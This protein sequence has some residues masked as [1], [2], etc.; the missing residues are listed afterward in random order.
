[1]RNSFSSDVP[2][3][4]SSPSP[5]RDVIAASASQDYVEPPNSA[6]YP[7]VKK[8]TTHFPDALFDEYDGARTRSLHPP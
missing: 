7:F 4:F 2:T 3:L 1:M 5:F 8:G 6:W